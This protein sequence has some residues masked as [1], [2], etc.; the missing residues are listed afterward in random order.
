M[1]I[2]FDIKELL[3]TGRDTDARRKEEIRTAVFVDESADRALVEKMRES[4]TPHLASG[5]LHVSV[6]S[7]ELP[8]VSTE[9]DIALIVAGSSP[10]IGELHERL[11]R[12][13]VPARTVTM[14][15]PALKASTQSAYVPLSL[16]NVITADTVDDMLEIVARWI[17]EETD[18]DLAFAANYPFIRHAMA[19]KIMND[20]AKQNALVGGVVMIPGADMPIMTANQMKM[21]LQIAA[22]YGKPMNAERLKELAAIVGGGFALRTAARQVIGLVP[23][24]GWAIK[25]GIG[26]TGTMAMGRAAIEYFDQGGNLDG[27]GKLISD[28]GAELGEKAGNVKNAAGG[29]TKR[30]KLPKLRR[31]KKGEQPD[32]LVAEDVSMTDIVISPALLPAGEEREL[33]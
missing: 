12:A 5:L 22:T 28:V 18:K 11:R 29:A 31:D 19:H 14:D 24:L 13:G 23:A 32:P 17:L 1:N 4:F 27:L 2:P 30:I 7:D 25:A 33:S 6:F 10:I 8:V 16:G 15:M 20:T 3:D 9:S 26:Y 21:L